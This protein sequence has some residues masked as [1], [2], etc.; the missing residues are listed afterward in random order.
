M[1]RGLIDGHATMHYESEQILEISKEATEVVY[2]FVETRGSIPVLWSQMPN[3]GLKAGPAICQDREKAT[4]EVK[5]YLEREEQK[6]QKLKAVCLLD[7]RGPEEALAT[8]FGSILTS[9]K[10]E[11]TSLLW[12]DYNAEYRRHRSAAFNH[13][14]DELKPEIKGFGFFKMERDGESAPFKV[15]REQMGAFRINCMHCHDRT[16]FI[17]FVIA[18]TYLH[19]FIADY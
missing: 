5:A 13:L 12:F 14:I 8:T 15:V 2:S 7:K 10:R 3:F 1:R 17:Q 18:R 19:L 6:E 9:L 11:K 4:K 16:N